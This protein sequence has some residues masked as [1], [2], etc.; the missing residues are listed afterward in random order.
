MSKSLI[1]YSK[2]LLKAKQ[3]TLKFTLFML[4]IIIVGKMKNL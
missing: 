4:V 1:L 2:K 3:K